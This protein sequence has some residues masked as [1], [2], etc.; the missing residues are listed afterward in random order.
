VIRVLIADDHRVVREGLRLVLTLD[1]EFNVVGEAM[2]GEE[3]VRLVHELRPDIVLMDLQMPGMDGIAATA[4]IKAA[5]PEVEVLVLTSVLQDTAVVG[6]VRAGATGYLHKDTDGDELRRAVKAAA[7]GQVQLSPEASR[8]LVREL[9]PSPAPATAD[10]DGP[11]LTERERDVVRL[12]ARGQSNREISTTLG[13]GEKTVKTHV[14]NVLAKFSV[15]SRTQAILYAQQ[16]GL[17]ARGPG[18][19]CA[20]A[21][22]PPDPRLE[23]PAR[24]AGPRR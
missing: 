16:H 9:Q 22:A 8:W 3:A 2:N 21:T 5:Q 11:P 1:P 20:G 14:R 23:Q 13:I 17:V 24:G 19:E 4:A 15:R 7:A 18:S 12:L 10:T 6:A